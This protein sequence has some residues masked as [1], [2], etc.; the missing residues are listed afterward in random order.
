LTHPLVDTSTMS[1]SQL[2]LA[3]QGA[4]APSGEPFG[5]AHELQ[6]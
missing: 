1:N 3:P 2:D 4:C 6:L 5:E